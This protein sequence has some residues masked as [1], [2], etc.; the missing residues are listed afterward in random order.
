LRSRRP[1]R[2]HIPSQLESWKKR[3]RRPERESPKVHIGFRLAPKVVAS[4]RAT[5]KGYKARVEKL[6][7][8]AL[9]TGKL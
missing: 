1:L 6:F 2:R 5:G 3:R 8:D 7:R 4:I 9:A